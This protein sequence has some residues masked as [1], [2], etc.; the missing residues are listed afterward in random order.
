MLM[1]FWRSDCSIS[2]T[3]GPPSDDNSELLI[4]RLTFLTVYGSR[5]PAIRVQHGRPLNRVVAVSV[6]IE[7][8]FSWP[9]SRR[10]PP[11]WIGG[12]HDKR[13]F[14]DVQP[15]YQERLTKGDHIRCDRLT[16]RKRIAYHRLVRDVTSLVR[17][18]MLT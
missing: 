18:T 4:G 15:Q 7:R 13:S 3:L 11:Q 5:S 12:R 16:R 14:L 8:N 17:H 1:G 10:R 6:L 2:H 9:N